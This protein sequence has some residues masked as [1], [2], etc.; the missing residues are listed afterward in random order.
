M[1]RFEESRIKSA[2]ALQIAQ[3]APTAVEAGYDD[4]AAKL[5][6][7]EFSMKAVPLRVKT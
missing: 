4:N 2:R 6:E 7:K 3:G 1:N 5:S